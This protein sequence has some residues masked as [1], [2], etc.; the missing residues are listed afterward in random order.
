[1]FGH[2]IATKKMDFISIW[3]GNKSVTFVSIIAVIAIFEGL[4]HIIFINVAAVHTVIICR[5]VVDVFVAAV[6]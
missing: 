4:V 3:V 2:I 5:V 1:M 6:A